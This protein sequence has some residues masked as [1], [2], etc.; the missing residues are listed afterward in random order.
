LIF[1]NKPPEVV[2][3][4]G[5]ESLIMSNILFLLLYP[6]SWRDGGWGQRGAKSY[7]PAQILSVKQI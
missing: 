4:G 1:K 6:E 7:L 5:A 2:L 3:K